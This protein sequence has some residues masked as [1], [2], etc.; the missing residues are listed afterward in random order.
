MSQEQIWAYYQNE[1]VDSFIDAKSRLDY[2]LKYAKKNSTLGSL[3]NIGCGSGYLE[4]AA[5]SNAWKTSS[6][7]PDQR[8]IDRLKAAGVDAHCGMI[9]KMPFADSSFD[10]VTCSEVLEHLSSEQLAV[11][12]LEIA[13]VL[14]PSGLIIG[15]TP[16][17]ENL[18]DNEFICINC[19]VRSHR[20]GHHQSFDEG[21]MRNL[22]SANFQIKKLGPKYFPT[23]R[24]NWKGK[25]FNAA[26]LAMSLCGADG[27]T[28]NL[29]FAARK[30]A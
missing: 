30:A 2:I 4:K 24:T 16:Y 22:L 17:K 9:E 21:K 3:L 8:A 12:I 19:G 15:T 28:S 29:F 5:L 1:A 18:P 23:W 14:K 13:R 7:D 26:L 27:K 25:M 10:V 11:G 6:L 20:W